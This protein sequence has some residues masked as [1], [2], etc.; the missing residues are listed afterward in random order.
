[1]IWLFPTLPFLCGLLCLLRPLHGMR[2]PFLG[3]SIIV[4][5]LIATLGTFFPATL[6]SRG[7][8]GIDPTGLFFLWMT[9]IVYLAVVTH[10]IL[11]TDCVRHDHGYSE[12]DMESVQRIDAID[13]ETELTKEDVRAGTDDRWFCLKP[14][15]VTCACISLSLSMMLLCVLSKHLGLLW[16]AIEG[17]TLATAPL[18]ALHHDK[19]SLEATWK[20]LILCSVGIAVALLGNFMLAASAGNSP[21]IM[22][23]DNLHLQSG[24]LNPVWLKA[25]FIFFLVG[26]G[27]KMGLV[28]MH[29]WL[30]DAHSEAPAPVSA[31]LSGATLNC[32]L[33]ALLRVHSVMTSAGLGQFSSELLMWFGALSICVAAMFMVEQSDYKRLLAYSSV[34]N[35]GI[36][37]LASGLHAGM[38]AMIHT[39]GHTLLKTAM[40]LLAGNILFRA[41]STAV[42]EVRG[43]AR[44]LPWTACLFMIGGLA[45]VGIPPSLLF[46]SKFSVIINLLGQRYPVLCLVT[47]LGLSIAAL[48]MLRTILYIVCAP[49]PDDDP[50]KISQEHHMNAPWRGVLV[51]AL[52]LSAGILGSLL[53]PEYVLNLLQSAAKGAGL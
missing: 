32:A 15:S 31:L 34:E 20:Y 7:W 49:P 24:I 45:M 25:A 4:P 19:R 36:I 6:S 48:G 18:I 5:L 3:F 53:A 23:L 44:R 12:A 38:G 14:F 52:L 37:A 2:K 11:D 35:M 22:T 43:L 1:M 33:L 30:P 47:V 39:A 21:L 50:D 29:S 13:D 17:T 10:I 41:G 42:M 46:F 9:L 8:L 16:V 40:F 51:P 27:T 26:Y 28:P